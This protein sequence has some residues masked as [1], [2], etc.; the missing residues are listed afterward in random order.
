MVVVDQSL[1]SKHAMLWV[2]SHVANKGDMLTLLQISPNLKKETEGS[3][4][5]PANHL[6]T[7]L[8]TL[9]KACKPEGQQEWNYFNSIATKNEHYDSESK[10]LPFHIAD[11]GSDSSSDGSDE[12]DQNVRAS[13]FLAVILAVYCFSHRF[14]F[15]LSD[16]NPTIIRPAKPSPE[17]HTSTPVVVNAPESSKV[18]DDVKGIYLLVSPYHTID[19]TRKE[20]GHQNQVSKKIN[21]EDE[22]VPQQGG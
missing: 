11:S 19:L 22:C 1:H 4:S 5:A 20:S 7:S 8:G 14:S 6:V 13:T 3:S 21:L 12:N 9:C 16:S 15:I 18:Y 10:K 2:L 17:P